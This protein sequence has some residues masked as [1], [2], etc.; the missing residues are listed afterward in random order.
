MWYAR[1]L[2]QAHAAIATI[3]EGEREGSAVSMSDESNRDRL[4]H[5]DPYWPADFEVFKHAREQCPVARSDAAGGYWLVTRYDDVQQILHNPRVFSSSDGI[6]IPHNPSAMM[7]PPIDV[8]PPLQRD[9][10]RLL[11]PCLAPGVLLSHAEVVRGFADTLIDA[12]IEHGACEFMSAFARPLPAMVLAHVVLQVSDAP[13]LLEVQHQAEAIASR[14]NSEDAARAWGFLQNFARELMWSEQRRPP[15][16]SIISALVHG[17]VEGRPLTEEEQVG[18][19]M[20]LLLGGLETTTGA[21]GNIV[22]Q[23]TVN[24]LLEH[25]VRDPA[26]VASDLDE[27]LRL[28]APVQW[29]GRTVTEP[30]E[31]GDV[32]LT[33]GDKVMAHLCSANRDQSAFIDAD[34]LRFDRSSNRHL[35]FGLG[36]HRCVGSHLARLELQLGFERLLRRMSGIRLA[37][38]E[39]IEFTEGMGR[40]PRQLLVLFDRL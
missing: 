24:P 15:D 26:W 12:F 35:S 10:R 33:P 7:M 23:M 9:F 19:V 11:N 38:G 6:T 37:E 20:I 18:A 39:H 31:L 28:D 17:K 4:S 34:R 36:A 40:A 29:L 21:F 30:Y 25:R 22:H 16:D 27:F 32:K 14:N 3:G 1:P 5:W 13:T 8:D 2:D